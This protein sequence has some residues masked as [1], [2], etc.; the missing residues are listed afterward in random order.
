MMLGTNTHTFYLTF[1]LQS[2]TGMTV[3]AS[4]VRL[5]PYLLSVTAAE[6]VVGTSVSIIGVYLPSMIFRTAIYTVASGL[7]C[8]RMSTPPQPT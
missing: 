7:L 3:S 6:L 5:L 4:S 8:T 2:A 1:Y